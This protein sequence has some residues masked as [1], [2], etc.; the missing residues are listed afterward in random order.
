MRRDSEAFTHF[1]LMAPRSSPRESPSIKCDAEW[2]EELDLRVF[3]ASLS[4]EKD[5][6][7]ILL[8]QG[9]E[10]ECGLVVYSPWKM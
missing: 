8:L 7:P 2:K 1:F 5:F 4:C 3:V 10:D 9:L 6:S